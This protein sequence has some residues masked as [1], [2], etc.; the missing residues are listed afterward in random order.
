[1]LTWLEE[2]AMVSG[3]TSAPH[4]IVCLLSCSLGC[5]PKSVSEIPPISGQV[6]PNRADRNVPDASTMAALLELMDPRGSNID[7]LDRQRAE[8]LQRVQ[9]LLPDPSHQE[10]LGIKNLIRWHRLYTVRLREHYRA[11]DAVQTQ[12][13][14]LLQP[15]VGR[16]ILVSDNGSVRDCPRP[17]VVT[18]PPATG[19]SDVQKTPAPA[20]DCQ[21]RPGFNQIEFQLQ[22]ATT[23]MNAVLEAQW[24][25]VRRIERVRQQLAKIQSDS[26]SPGTSP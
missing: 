1:M 6:E 7:R 4:I 20:P 17:N 2:K 11:L 14:E 21:P 16:E 12:T 26:V 5:E 19:P 13:R 24:H 3:R 18:T 22:A 8:F 23:E 9:L 15:R 25:L 10:A